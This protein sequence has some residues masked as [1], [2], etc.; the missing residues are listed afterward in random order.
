MRIVVEVQQIAAAEDHPGRRRR[1]VDQGRHD[2]AIGLQRGLEVPGHL[3]GPG[4]GLEPEV[5]VRQG[6]QVQQVLLRQQLEP[7]AQDGGAAGTTH[8]SAAR[9]AASEIL[10]SGA[11]GRLLPTSR[12]RCP[13]RQG[14]PRPP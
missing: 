13:R 9:R 3:G 1:P 5:L 7:P 6:V 12:A 11:L 10:R 8:R 2:P 4:A 14:R